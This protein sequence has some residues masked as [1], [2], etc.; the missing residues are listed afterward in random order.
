MNKNLNI[1]LP[2]PKQGDTSAL[3]ELARWVKGHGGVGSSFYVLNDW[4]NGIQT[5]FRYRLILPDQGIDATLKEGDKIT[6]RQGKV[7]VKHKR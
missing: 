6:L 3:L 4:D 2:D 7:E 5:N 1:T